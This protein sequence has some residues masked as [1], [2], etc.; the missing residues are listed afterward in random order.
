[1][2][3]GCHRGSGISREQYFAEKIIRIM[4][5][6]LYAK[7]VEGA[8]LKLRQVLEVFVP[9]N[10]LEFYHDIKSLSSRFCQP[11]FGHG[12]NIL[13][14]LMTDDEDLK[15][16]LA[17]REVLTDISLILIL[18]DG[19]PET[20]RAGHLL[21]P[22]FVSCAGRDFLEIGAVLNKMLGNSSDP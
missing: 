4:K 19:R 9:H 2:K 6:L 21:R 5:V 14:A 16:M 18:P 3:T 13:V 17:I 7:Q 11:G 8:G 10:R 1:M 20:T 12:R 22:R 15:Q